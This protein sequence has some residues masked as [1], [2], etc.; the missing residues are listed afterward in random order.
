MVRASRSEGSQEEGKGRRGMDTGEVLLLFPSGALAH[1]HQRLQV[2]LRGFLIVY[3][4]PCIFFVS[5][6]V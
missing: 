5:S 4:L 1:K 6:L 3:F 2:F